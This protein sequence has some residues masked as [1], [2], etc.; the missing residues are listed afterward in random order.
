MR[1]MSGKSLDNLITVCNRY[2][3]KEFELLE[4]ESRIS[5]AAIPDRLSKE[6]GKFLD[7][8]DNE[9]ERIR[10][11]ELE[12]SWEKLGHQLADEL[13]QAVE[14]EKERGYSAYAEE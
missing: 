7:D 13:I 2:K 5:T 8:F 4:F 9:V 1:T 11:C 14:A 10:F 12:E 3:Q 6:F